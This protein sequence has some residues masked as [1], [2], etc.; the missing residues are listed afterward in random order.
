M[1]K[2]DGSR[3][4]VKSAVTDG[5]C[6]IGFLSL[7]I[8]RSLQRIK[9]TILYGTQG[10]IKTAGRGI[11]VAVRNCRCGT[12]TE[13]PFKTVKTVIKGAEINL[14]SRTN[15]ILISLEGDIRFIQ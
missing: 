12:I 3:I 5:V 2:G 7:N 1:G 14:F 6:G 15:E 10:Y 4:T 13:I 9:T 8:M 11:H